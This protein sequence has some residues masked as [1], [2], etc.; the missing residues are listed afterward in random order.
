MRAFACAGVVC[1]LL[2]VTP[3]AAQIEPGA[4]MITEY[5]TGSIADIS[6]GGSFAGTERF[7]TGLSGPTGLCFGPGGALFVA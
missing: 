3:V 4:L 7:A 6:A 5:D 2:G 1:A